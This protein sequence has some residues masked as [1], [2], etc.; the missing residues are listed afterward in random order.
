MLAMVVGE[1]FV[2]ELGHIHARRALGFAGFALQAQIHHAVDF[3]AV[4]AV[5]Q[6]TGQRGAQGIGPAA[7]GV[8]LVQGRHVRRTHRAHQLFAAVAHPRAHFNGFLKTTR[9][10]KAE[11]RLDLGRLILL[12]V[13]QVLVHS[14]RPGDL[15]G[16][17][18]ALWI[19]G[20]LDL[21]KGRDQLRAKHLGDPLA[22]RQTIAVLA[23]HGSAVFEHHIAHPLLHLAQE[24]YALG[25]FEAE[26]RPDVQ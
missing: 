10:A 16:V 15:A 24:L 12:V 21:D 5:G 3:M 17:H 14:K 23:R 18:N 6:R 8:L 9:L 26:N 19:K 25:V 1:K 22:A 7:R 13:T 4:Q 2:L 20:V 11:K